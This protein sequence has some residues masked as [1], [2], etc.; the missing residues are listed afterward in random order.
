MIAASA[1]MGR[2]VTVGG[3]PD[4]RSTMNTCGEPLE[5]SQTEMN[6]SLSIA[7]VPNLIAFDDTPRLGRFKTS[8]KFTGM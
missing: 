2:F 1:D 6:F 7:H 5:L 8:E 4:A 3:F